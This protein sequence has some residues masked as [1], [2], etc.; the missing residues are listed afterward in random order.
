MANVYF[1]VLNRNI[2][3]QYA[4]NIISGLQKE[5]SASA[6]ILNEDLFDVSRTIGTHRVGLNVDSLLKYYLINQILR[7]MPEE[8]KEKNIVRKLA[9]TPNKKYKKDLTTNKYYELYGK[10]WVL[11]KDVVQVNQDGSYIINETKT[12]STYVYKKVYSVNDALL[13]IQ[14]IDPE[15]R[16]VNN[17]NQAIE[18]IGLRKELANGNKTVFS[19]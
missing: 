19:C 9:F 1:K 5:L 18:L 7:N 10:E 11:A 16:I 8:N 12:N 13:S 6:M 14:V 3:N 17:M 15:G 4:E 2:R